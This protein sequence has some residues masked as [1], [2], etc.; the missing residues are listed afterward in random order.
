LDQNAEFR[1]GLNSGPANTFEFRSATLRVVQGMQRK[2]SDAKRE[3]PVRREGIG[4]SSCKAMSSYPVLRNEGIMMR[5]SCVE[6][7][8]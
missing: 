6:E 3:V 7:R 2:N 8:E 5:R 1:Y 4:M